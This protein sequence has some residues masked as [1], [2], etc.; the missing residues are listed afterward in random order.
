MLD[1]TKF[2]A[3]YGIRALSQYHRAH[4]YILPV[5]GTEHRVDYEP[6]E[7]SIPLFWRQF[8]LAWTHLVPGQFSTHR[9][10]AEVSSLLPG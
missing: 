10:L 7:S 2:L 6:A 8:Q 1:E 3:P 9:V 5:N 4:P